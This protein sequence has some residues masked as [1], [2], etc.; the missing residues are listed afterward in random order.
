MQS[1]DALKTVF[2]QLVQAFSNQDL[3]AL[4]TLAHENIV[5]LGVLSPIRAEG[6]PAFLQVFKNFFSLHDRMHIT[7]LDPHFQEIDAIG[8]A[9]GNIMLEIQP[10]GLDS[11]TM[12]LRYS[13]TFAYHTGMWSLVAMHT[14]RLLHNEEPMP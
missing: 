6:K 12:Y 8:L 10:R 13:C 2:E 11:K 9:W 7:P 1:S 14:S 3:D 5:C 4:S